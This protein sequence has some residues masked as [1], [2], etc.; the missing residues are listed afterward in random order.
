MSSQLRLFLEPPGFL[1]MN[2]Q[3]T[4]KEGSCLHWLLMS[5][6]YRRWYT[7]GR[8]LFHMGAKW[9]GWSDIGPRLNAKNL[10]FFLCHPIENHFMLSSPCYIIPFFGLFL[11]VHS[12]IP[13]RHCRN[14]HPISS[15]FCF[16]F[17]SLTAITLSLL[18]A[19]HRVKPPGT[20]PVKGKTSRP[21]RVRCNYGYTHPFTL[22]VTHLRK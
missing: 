9:F 22:F 16:V 6:G 4:P 3:T 15:S 19:L 7:G 11:F 13:W 2:Q 8:K 17:L 21:S 18:A 1:K 5:R 20:L 14:H 12:K 10:G